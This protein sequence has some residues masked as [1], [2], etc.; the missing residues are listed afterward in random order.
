MVIVVVTVTVLVVGFTYLTDVS[1]P[2]HGSSL[3]LKYLLL[4][5][6]GTTFTELRSNSLSCMY[7][8]IYS[9]LVDP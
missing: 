8:S 5:R 6:Q 4:P 3:N 1:A 2:R 9:Y 7:F